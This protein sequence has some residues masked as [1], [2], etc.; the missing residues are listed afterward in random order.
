MFVQVILDPNGLWNVLPHESDVLGIGKNVVQVEV[1]DI[2]ASYSGSRS[3][4]HT[5]DEAL[6]G[7]EIC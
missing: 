7:D 6:D 4:G 5:V 3:G 1:F 2:I